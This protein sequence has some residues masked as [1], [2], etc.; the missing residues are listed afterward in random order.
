M[1][2][3]DWPYGEDLALEGN[4][5]RA[6]QRRLDD[7]LSELMLISRKYQLVID[8]YVGYEVPVVRDVESGTVV[9][10]Q[11][12]YHVDVQHPTHVVS[13]DFAGGSILDG[14]WLVDTPQGPVALRELDGRAGLARK[15]AKE[16][17]PPQ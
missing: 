9:G 15:H 14:V 12:A 7:F 8:S 6:Q 2:M 13:Y 16:G 11:L 17:V 1:T 5:T 10:L 4:P 3:N